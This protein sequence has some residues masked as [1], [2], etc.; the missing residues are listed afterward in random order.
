MFLA[1]HQMLINNCMTY[2]WNFA[3][4]SKVHLNGSLFPCGVCIVKYPWHGVGLHQPMSVPFRW[5]SFC[6]SH[7]QGQLRVMLHPLVC[8]YTSPSIEHNLLFF[9]FLYFTF[10]LVHFSVQDMYTKNVSKCP[11][12]PQSLKT[13][14]HLWGAWLMK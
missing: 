12:H 14:L 7:Y 4:C 1:P 6:G 5:T 10:P 13:L 11:T 8:L 9:F 2:L 3:K